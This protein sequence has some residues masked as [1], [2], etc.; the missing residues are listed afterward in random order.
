[1]RNIIK[2]H[3]SISSAEPIYWCYN[4]SCLLLP[5]ICFQCIRDE[6]ACA[7]AA[8]LSYLIQLTCSRRSKRVEPTR[9]KLNWE[10]RGNISIWK[11]EAKCC[12]NNGNKT[13]ISTRNSAISPSILFRI[14]D[15]KWKQIVALKFI[16]IEIKRRQASV[17]VKWKKEDTK[18]IEV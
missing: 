14:V 16:V 2:C 3:N 4:C 18:L 8:F 15:S 9:V 17:N 11:T 12:S 13:T 10:L 7:S 6:A 5:S 1:M